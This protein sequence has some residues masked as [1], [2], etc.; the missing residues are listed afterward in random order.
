MF[1]TKGLANTKS[2][3]MSEM[4]I[5]LFFRSMLLIYG[6]RLYLSYLI[7]DEIPLALKFKSKVTRS[8]LIPSSFPDSIFFLV[9]YHLA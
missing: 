8:A 9:I 2:K 7:M 3:S 1:L 5:C 6:I 4:K